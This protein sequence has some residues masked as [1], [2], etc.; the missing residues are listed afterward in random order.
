M[1]VEIPDVTTMDRALTF[2][3]RNS[4]NDLAFAMDDDRVSYSELNEQAGILAGGMRERGIV[5]GDRLAILAPSS[6]DFIRLYFAAHRLHCIPCAFDPG[7]PAKTVVRRALGIRPR[8][9][10]ATGSSSP[11]LH[12]AITAT[13]I[14][15]LTVDDLRR[16]SSSVSLLPGAVDGDIAYLQPTSGTSGEPRFA[17]ITNRNIA[18]A[19][20][21]GKDVAG[22]EKTNTFVTWLPPWHDLGLIRFTLAPIVVGSPAHLVRP[23]IRTIPDWLSAIAR[24]RATI[25][26]GPD[27][28]IRLMT[29]FA[30]ASADL[31]SLRHVVDGGEP[32]RKSTIDAFEERFHLPGVIRPGYGLAEATLGV[33]MVLPG[34]KLRLD[35]HGNVSCGRAMPGT[36]LR[37]DE[38]GEI[39]VRSE[40]VFAGYFDAPEATGELLRGGWLHTGDIGHLDAD[41]YLYVLGRKRALLKRGGA[42]LA[43]RELEEAAQLVRGV[44]AAAAVGLEDPDGDATERIIVAVEADDD[45]VSEE[46]SQ[47]VAREIERAIGFAP[48]RVLVLP[49]RSIP[50]TENG[51]I[52]HA[53]LRSMIANGFNQRG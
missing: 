23:A 50:T 43:P 39:L 53:A 22:V 19:M 44:R 29:R 35:P 12:A 31:S 36:E 32:V 37:I 24:E 47:N 52:R 49:P 40:Q 16:S 2:R 13:K 4:P 27:F 46:L 38:D 34:E 33:A 26:A 6:V 10:L 5:A 9:I 41:G 18:A 1:T 21:N 28:A 3:A 7:V 20:E 51:K 11:D 14:E 17:M 45:A 15:L 42:L 25:T 30:D 48:E 8:A